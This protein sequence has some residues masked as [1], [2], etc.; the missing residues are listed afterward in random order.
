MLCFLSAGL[1]MGELAR[2]I[3]LRLA[4]E[5]GLF[6][7]RIPE[8]LQTPGTLTTPQ[9]GKIDHDTS[10]GLQSTCDILTDAFGLEAEQLAPESLQAVSICLQPLLWMHATC[11]AMM[12][13]SMML[14]CAALTMLLSMVLRW[15]ALTRLL[16]VVFHCTTLT[17][18]TTWRQCL[19]SRIACTPNFSL[20]HMH[21]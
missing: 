12:L 21:Q 16:N 6:G 19:Q 2:R 4:T 14:H 10:D 9:M 1:Y 3:I 18:S 5:G 11:R 20:E 17:S 15:T 7:A 8:K 13:L